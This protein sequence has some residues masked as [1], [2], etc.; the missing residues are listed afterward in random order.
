MRLE[1]CPGCERHIRSDES[2]CPFCQQTVAFTCTGPCHGER[3]LSRA[4]V[5]FL[6]AAALTACGKE[7]MKHDKG[8]VLSVAAYA[9]V[10]I[11]ASYMIEPPSV[12]DAGVVPVEPVKVDPSRDAGPKKPTPNR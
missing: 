8:P 2:A 5:V 6:G 7:E 10:P 12:M 9:P 1:L 3:A 4:A 11:D